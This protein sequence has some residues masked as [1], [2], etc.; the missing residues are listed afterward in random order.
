MSSFSGGTRWE[1]LLNT[2]LICDVF[3]RA[4]GVAPYGAGAPASAVAG[5]HRGAPAILLR[6]S[7]KPDD[8]VTSVTLVVPPVAAAVELGEAVVPVK[9]DSLSPMSV[10]APSSGEG[11]GMSMDRLLPRSSMSSG[12]GGGL[13]H[14]LL[15]M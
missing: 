1:N 14:R 2:A 12:V 3:L 9:S 5:L 8:W 13:F 4:V 10:A 7:V 11:G 15:L 6:S